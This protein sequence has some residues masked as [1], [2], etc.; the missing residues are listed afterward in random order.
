M[1]ALLAAYIGGSAPAQ[2]PI[3]RLLGLGVAFA[4]PDWQRLQPARPRSTATGA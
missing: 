2:N 1:R 4:P 3:G